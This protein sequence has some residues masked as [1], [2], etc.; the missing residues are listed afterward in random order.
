MGIL[1]NLLACAR[2]SHI[3]RRLPPPPFDRITSCAA[4]V[5]AGTI[6]YASGWSHNRVYVQGNVQYHSYMHTAG[7]WWQD[8]TVDHTFAAGKDRL[9]C[10]LQNS[11]STVAVMVERLP[12]P[13][14]PTPCLLCRPC[15]VLHLH[16]LAHRCF[17]CAPCRCPGCSQRP[18]VVRAN[19]LEL[20]PRFPCWWRRV[21]WQR[22]PFPHFNHL[23]RPSH[24]KH[25]MNRA[26]TPSTMSVWDTTRPR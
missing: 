8:D 19:V 16:P 12:K 5:L 24:L 20:R 21:R 3:F 11:L 22:V 13:C 1:G 14:S 2:S 10:W 25:R 4:L 26:S 18:L 15:H 7:C 6:K 23:G 9:R 17:V